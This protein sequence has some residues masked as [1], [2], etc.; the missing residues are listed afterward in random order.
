[1]QVL[2]TSK[3]SQS[4][5]KALFPALSLL[6]NQL[7]FTAASVSPLCSHLLPF[8]RAVLPR[9]NLPPTPPPPAAAPVLSFAL[10]DTCDGWGFNSAARH[11]A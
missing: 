9:R 6:Q 2:T 5:Q 7:L 1:M 11:C 10:R 3:S 8:H 4:R